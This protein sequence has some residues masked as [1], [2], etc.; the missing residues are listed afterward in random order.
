MLTKAQAMTESVNFNE[1][2]QGLWGPQYIQTTVASRNKGLKL[3]SRLGYFVCRLL[4]YVLLKMYSKF[5][6][7]K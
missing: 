7:P 5:G 1:F 4:I 6:G 2:L 3:V